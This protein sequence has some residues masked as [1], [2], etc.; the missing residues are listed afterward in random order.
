MSSNLSEAERLEACFKRIEQEQ[1]QGIPLLNHAIEVEAVGFAERQGRLMGVIVTPWFM[2]ILMLPDEEDDWD[3][4]TLGHEMRLEFPQKKYDFMFNEFDGVGRCMTF[5]LRS[6]MTC[7]NSHEEAVNAA[8]L[9]LAEM[10]EEK[11]LGEE[12]MEAERLRRFL[13]GD[14]SA[15][16]KKDDDEDEIVAD[17]PPPNA[18]KK[19]KGL[20]RRE[21]LRGRA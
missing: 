11:E 19:P 10:M 2:S 16:L 1:M 12:D 6:P 9:A 3:I 7:F 14:E 15:L 4:E 17:A 18:D 21:L 8:E 13:K 5:A 20:S